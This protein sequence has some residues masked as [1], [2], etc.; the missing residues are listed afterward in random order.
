MGNDRSF[1]SEND[2]CQYAEQSVRKLT[3]WNAIF[4]VHNIGEKYGR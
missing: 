2:L 3:T 1:S 4:I